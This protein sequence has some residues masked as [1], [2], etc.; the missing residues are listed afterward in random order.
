[1]P[2]ASA[3]SSSGSV[4]EN[5]TLLVQ[6]PTA[7]QVLLLRNEPSSAPMITVGTAMMIESS[8]SP[9]NRA[10]MPAFRPPGTGAGGGPYPYGAGGICPAGYPG[11]GAPYGGGLG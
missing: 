7:S 8:T 10:P 4:P 2:S 11:C 1:M 3:M 6:L 5:C 9:P